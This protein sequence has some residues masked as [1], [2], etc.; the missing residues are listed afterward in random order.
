MP[1]PRRDL[2][3]RE[4][5]QSH[6]ELELLESLTQPEVPYPW[7]PTDLESEAYF[8]TLEAEVTPLWLT[9]EEFAPR[10]QTAIASFQKLWSANSSTTSAVEKV[11]AALLQKFGTQVPSNWLEAIA[12]QA[13]NLASTQTPTAQRLVECVSAL[14]PQWTPEDLQVL[15]RPF[16]YAMR[17][18]SLES[19]VTTITEKTWSNLSEIEKARLSLAIARYAVSEVENLSA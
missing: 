15:A 19:T 8:S 17:G 4:Y 2:E 6:L 1:N 18:E 16:A 7:N 3:C 10:A 11:R 14:L 13:R 12:D 5:S 9:E